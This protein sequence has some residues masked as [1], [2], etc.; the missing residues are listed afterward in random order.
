MPLLH[1]RSFGSLS[2]LLDQIPSASSSHRPTTPDKPLPL[3]PQPSGSMPLSREPEEEDDDTL[4]P[5]VSASSRSSASPPMSKR[6]HALIELLTSERAYASD[7]ALIRDIH[8]PLAL[9][10]SNRVNPVPND[11]PLTD[12]ILPS[13]PFDPQC[14]SHSHNVIV[15]GPGQPAPF[16]ATPATPP[17]SSA[18]SSRTLSTASDSS[19]ASYLSVGGPPMTREDTKII[20]NNVSELAVFSEISKRFYEMTFDLKYR[21][22]SGRLRPHRSRA[23]LV[24]LIQ[25]PDIA[26]RVEALDQVGEPFGRVGA[27]DALRAPGGVLERGGVEAEA[28]HLLGELYGRDE[29]WF[30]AYAAG[31]VARGVPHDG[32]MLSSFHRASD[33]DGAWPSGA[34]A[35]CS[36]IPTKLRKTII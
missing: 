11:R 4:L 16:A 18:S 22:L 35:C 34:G 14:S 31:V 30:R 36:V 19:A 6:N 28:L 21:F 24:L 17:G 15:D 1:S 7:L 9:G 32:S 12:S 26:R 10:T 2:G 23:L 27:P 20:F 25:R 33:L 29:I 8:I 5:S 13:P 3:T